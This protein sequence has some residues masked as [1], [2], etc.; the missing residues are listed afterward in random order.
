[1]FSKEQFLRCIVTTSNSRAVESQVNHLKSISALDGRAVDAGQY[2]TVLENAQL[3][4]T[5]N[6]EELRALLKLKRRGG[7]SSL[8]R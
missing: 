7:F 2:L 4:C 1:M 5:E 8:I 3:K 6:F